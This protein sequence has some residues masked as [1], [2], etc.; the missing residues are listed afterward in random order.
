[1]GR[2]P[3]IGS[4][5]EGSFGDELEKEIGLL[6]REQRREADDREKELNMYR[7]GS[8]PPTVEGSLSA[9]G[10]LFNNNHGQGQSQSQTNGL[11]FSEFAGG[12]GFRSED[13]LRADPAYIS[14]YYSNM[15]LNP[16]LPPPLVSKEDWRFTQ[17][18]QGGG[19]SGLGGI[20]DRR[21]SNRSD[22]GG[23]S[24]GGGGGGGVSLFSMPPGFNS[25][26]QENENS[27]AEK[28][29]ASAEWGGDG[30]IGL[31][32]LG[33]GSKQKSLAEIFQDDLSR[34]TPPSGHPSRPASRTAFENNDEPL[35]HADAELAQS[36]SVKGQPTS[37]SYAAAL[38][39]SLSRSTTPDPQHIARVPSPIPTPIGGGRVNPSDRRNPNGPGLFNGA[40]SQPKDPA[41]LVTTLS[42]MNLSN[43]VM[44]EES[45]LTQ[46]DQN[47]DDQ[48]AFRLNMLQNPKSNKNNLYFDGSS[49][50]L[51]S[52]Y[53]HNNGGGRSY[54]NNGSSGHSV[55]SVNSPQMMSSQHGGSLNLP[56]LFETAAAASVMGYPGMESRFG[57]ESPNMSRLM[58]QMSGNTLQGSLMDPMYL[59]Y[60]RSTEY[61][62]AA[63]QIAALND[64]TIDRSNYLGNS[65][66]DLLQKA[67]LGSLLSPQKSQYGGVPY[68]GS[69]GSPHHH[70]YYGN[71]AFGMSYPGSPL[72]GPLPNS[73]GGPGSPMRL[74]ELNARFSPQMRNL[75]GGS[76]VMGHWHLDGGEST[77]ASSLLEEFKSNKTRSFELSEI[78]GH[79]VEFSADQYGSRFIQQKLET[80]TTEDKNMVFQEIFP[81]ALTL[82][83]DVFG[84]YVIQK[85]FEHGMPAQRRELAG[86]LLGHVLSLSLQMYGCR[87]IQKAIEVVDLDQKIKMVEEL[88]GHIMR[89]VRDQNGNHVIQKCIECVPEEHIQFIITT[90]FDQVVVLSTHPYGCRVIQRVLEHC[91]DPKTQS[92]VMDEILACVS[93]LA[94]DQYGNYVVQ[95]VLEHGKPHERSII[96]QELAGKIVQMSQQKFASN[97]VE[98]CLTFGDASERHLLMNEMLGTTDENEPL[99]A[100]MKD[101]FANYVV[102][103]VLET[104]SDQERE[105][106][107]SRIKVHL[108]ALK[109]YTYG[110]HIVARVEKLV[111]AGER[112]M[113]A[114]SAH[115]A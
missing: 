97:V 60:L 39:A 68:V 46:F 29:K 5:G 9:V 41:D 1:M 24:V 101:Q 88:D 115:A 4:G 14:Y 10:G 62:A 25:K 73:P 112:R 70:G 35:G 30:L 96:I 45:N 95:H 80:A 71:P 64:P 105:H 104:C 43:G 61:A 78:N 72:A 31:P 48:N 53:Q 100:M 89:C 111:A 107:L 19:G 22:G 8:A 109:K 114:Q 16:R 28:V 94:Q 108:N 37:Y 63:A 54:M 2:R 66:E 87:V 13:E 98:K 57:L 38:G 102:Q 75:G 12:N 91:E 18:L 59:Q 23:A 82:M 3:V 110:K 52:Q 11:G 106:I 17:R 27:E 42:G 44:G 93:M 34:S 74:G 65:Y 81:Q 99:Q 113:A 103:K 32:G 85:F 77:F 86:K 92:K 55:N 84:N 67:Y 21:K 47:A 76:G 15:K 36:H 51:Q 26:K 33:L 7:S 79:V 90:F 83:T 40:M 20:G 58:N 69:S 49:S 6:L 50:N 56:P